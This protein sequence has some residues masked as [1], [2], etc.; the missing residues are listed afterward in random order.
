M[1]P[2]MLCSSDSIEILRDLSFVYVARRASTIFIRAARNAGSTPPTN[3]MIREK[4]RDFQT[5]STVRVKLKASS[6]KV[7][8]FMVEMVMSCMNEAQKIPATPP[9]AR[10]T[11]IPG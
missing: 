3:P 6:E 8:Q 11:A 9:E 4:S 7:A 1:Y 2:L 10:G 5:I